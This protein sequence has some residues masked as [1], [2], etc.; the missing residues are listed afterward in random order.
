[1]APR[2]PKDYPTRGD[3]G[4][5][6]PI[7]AF[8]RASLGP[9][10]SWA[11]GSL[12]VLMVWAGGSILTLRDSHSTLTAEF[13]YVKRDLEEVRGQLRSHLEAYNALARRVAVNIE[14]DRNVHQNVKPSSR[15]VP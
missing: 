13:I 4:E 7:A 15:R 1:M 3:G 14:E 12:T 6:R 11:L 5:T 2:Q 9:L 10:V 8:F